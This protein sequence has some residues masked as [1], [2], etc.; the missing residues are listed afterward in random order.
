M[1][2]KKDVPALQPPYLD[3]Q[4]SKVPDHE[5][6]PIPI[7]TAA[8]LLPDGST[9]NFSVLIEEKPEAKFSD[10]TQNK[11]AAQKAVNQI[12]DALR[13]GMYEQILS[14][15]DEVNPAGTKT[16]PMNPS[17]YSSLFASLSTASLSSTPTLA[18]PSGNSVLKTLTKAFPGIKGAT[19]ECPCRKKKWGVTLGDSCVYGTN[20][21]TPLADTVIH[22]NDV[23]HWTRDQIADWLD[24]LD[25]D[26]SA[27]PNT[28]KES[29]A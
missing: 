1:S 18:G 22:L 28:E 20:A 14:Q 19:V 23:H 21:P 16:I 10:T 25:I 26:L 3:V 5:G 15:L 8:V 13:Q 17:L 7:A 9:L 24:T 2:N 29:A 11:H 27:K 6:T 12:I 4:V